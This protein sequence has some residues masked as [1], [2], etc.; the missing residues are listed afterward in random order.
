[1]A[2]VSFLRVPELSTCPSH[3]NCQLSNSQHLYS[4]SRLTL[5]KPFNNV[6][7]SQLS[8]SQL[9]YK[10]KVIL[11]PVSLSRVRHPSGTRGQCFFLIFITQL[12]VCWR[13]A[14]Y[15]M[16][17]LV[18]SLLL[19]FASADFLGFEARGNHSYLLLPKIW[20]SSNLDSPG[21]LI[22]S[23]QGTGYPS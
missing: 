4:Q 1:M 3:R 20:S 15:L 12:P 8:S 19:D 5:Y 17:G 23:P 13:R 16:R 7:S 21:S 18:W 14:P 10:V 6:V 2:D 9:L 11:R 22:Y